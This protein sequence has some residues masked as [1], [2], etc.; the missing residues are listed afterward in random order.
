MCAHMGE[1]FSA[2]LLLQ[3]CGNNH[4]NLTMAWHA[5]RVRQVRSPEKGGLGDAVANCGQHAYISDAWL[6]VTTELGKLEAQDVW[7]MSQ[8]TCTHKRP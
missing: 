8:M 4:H 6:E 1:C 5:T 2:Q 7:I 3:C